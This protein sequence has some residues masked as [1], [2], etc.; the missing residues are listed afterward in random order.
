MLEDT[1]VP[2]GDIDDTEDTELTGLLDG[3]TLKLET[4]DATPPEL[5]TKMINEIAD[6]QFTIDSADNA[7][8][9]KS[10]F[11]T[12]EFNRAR[13]YAPIFSVDKKGDQVVVGN[14]IIHGLGYFVQ[15]LDDFLWIQTNMPD[16]GTQYILDAYTN[17]DTLHDAILTEAYSQK[18]SDYTEMVQGVRSTYSGILSSGLMERV[19]RDVPAGQGFLRGAE[20][21]AKIKQEVESLSEDEKSRE[22]VDSFSW[23]VISE[24]VKGLRKRAGDVLEDVEPG[25]TLREGR[26]A[27]DPAYVNDLTNYLYANAEFMGGLRP[28]IFDLRQQSVVDVADQIL[29][30]GGIGAA[31]IIG[32]R[33]VLMLEQRNKA[34]YESRLEADEAKTKGMIDALTGIPNRARWN[35]LI[36]TKV[37]SQRTDGHTVLILDF[38]GFKRINDY[39]YQELDEVDDSGTRKKHRGHPLGD[40]VLIEAAHAM[41][42]GLGR[43]G[44]VL[45]RYGGE[46]FAIFI[47]KY[48]SSKDVLAIMKK[49]DDLLLEMSR[50]MKIQYD[51]DKVPPEVLELDPHYAELGFVRLGASVGASRGKVEKKIK[52]VVKSADEV[53]ALNKQE[54]NTYLA[55]NDRIGVAFGDGFEE[56]TTLSDLLVLAENEEIISEDEMIIS[57]EILDGGR[58]KDPQEFEYFRVSIVRYNLNDRKLEINYEPFAADWKQGVKLV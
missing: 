35:E 41:Q 9:V 15:L 7:D 39:V 34:L 38:A 43:E 57:R 4:V 8:K 25:P 58:S 51:P 36:D 29:S 31:K 56:E 46:E 26:E 13:C 20:L 10:L 22:N 14:E 45:C 5:L 32:Q 19:N 23:D 44:D 48:L 37:N 55:Y 12:V 28:S 40:D 24:V 54:G 50:K 47:P 30:G 52:G 53:L 33:F 3:S 1:L 11:K 27:L 49:I 2:L 16:G 6:F 18:P 42:S 17:A 21:R